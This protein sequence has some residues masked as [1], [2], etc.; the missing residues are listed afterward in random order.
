MPGDEIPIFFL[1]DLVIVNGDQQLFRRTGRWKTPRENK[2]RSYGTPLIRT[3]DGR[4]QMTKI[5][6]GPT[7]QFVASMVY[8]GKHVFVTGG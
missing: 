5:I 8:D 3:I 6:D 7:E 1:A 2:T 4:D